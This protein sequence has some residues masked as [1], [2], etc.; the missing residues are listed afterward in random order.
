MGVENRVKFLG[1][2]VSLVGCIGETARTSLNII[3]IV[4]LSCNCACTIDGSS[5]EI[6]PFEVDEK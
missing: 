3:E 1:V 4:N 5:A 2:Y 6:I